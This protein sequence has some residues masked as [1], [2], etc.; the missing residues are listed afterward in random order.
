MDM[1]SAIYSNTTPI[2]QTWWYAK[3]DGR[4]FHGYR[5]RV[6]YARKADIKAVMRFTAIGEQVRICADNYWEFTTKQTNRYSQAARQ[7]RQKI[8]DMF[9][10]EFFNSGRVEF[11]SVTV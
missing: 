2:T 7:E 10:K 11:G 8:R 5:G 3:V 9:W 1:R 4:T 6:F